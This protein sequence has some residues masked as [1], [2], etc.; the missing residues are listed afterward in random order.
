MISADKGSDIP[1]RP[2]IVDSLERSEG[3]RELL[4]WVL[5]SGFL[6]AFWFL[7]I[8]L[9]SYIHNVLGGLGKI[10]CRVGTTHCRLSKGR[11]VSLGGGGKWYRRSGPHPGAITPY[12]WAQEPP[13]YIEASLLGGEDF[14]ARHYSPSQ[15]PA[16]H[17]SRSFFFP[18]HHP[19]IAPAPHL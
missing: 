3:N 17:S 10:G 5:V 11:V 6:C 9:I 7:V 18:T 2:P 14:E 19:R 15:L 1:L 12:P 4:G 16:R 13:A 8:S